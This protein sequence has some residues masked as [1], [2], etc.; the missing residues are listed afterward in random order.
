MSPLQTLGRTILTGL[1]LA[2]GSAYG[3]GGAGHR[4]V[5]DLPSRLLTSKAAASVAFLLKDD[6]GADGLPSGRTT[7]ADVSSWADEYRST[8]AGRRTAS[9]HYENIEVCGEEP[10]SGRCPGGNCITSK[11]T[12]M[13]AVLKDQ[14]ATYRSRNEALKWIVHLVGDI[15]QPLH[16][17]NNHDK[18]GNEVAVSFSGGGRGRSVSLNLHALW[19]TNLVERLM[20]EEGSQAAFSATPVLD[21]DRRTWEEG[22]VVDWL[23]ESHALAASEVYGRLPGGLSCNKALAVPLQIGDDYYRGASQVISIQLQRSGVRL[24]KILNDA[25]E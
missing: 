5:A 3:W 1:L 8:G 18:G 17:A 7:L 20:R 9:W 11:I 19:D 15:H 2:G 24:A 12:Q 21:S 16:A 22:T 23:N 10:A 25:F 13:V 6:L 4:A 14:E